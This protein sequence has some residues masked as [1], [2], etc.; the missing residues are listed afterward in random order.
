MIH[1]LIYRSKAKINLN[2]LEI[3][4]IWST[5]EETNKSHNI[6]GCLIFF[7]GR[8]L[9]IIEGNR[10][11]IEQLYSNIKADNRHTEITTLGRFN[12]T[13]RLF[14]N[15]SMAYLKAN[16]YEQLSSSEQF[17]NDQLEEFTPPKDENNP[18]SLLFWIKAKGL[19]VNQTPK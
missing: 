18:A 15:W 11:H 19:L 2:Q 13:E 9:Q 12:S 8:F 6:S 7:K 16:E 5:A 17:L 4:D 1:Q 10:K 14:K 3:E